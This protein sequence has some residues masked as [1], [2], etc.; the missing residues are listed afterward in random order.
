ML[1]RYRFKAPEYTGNA[2]ADHDNLTRAV[3]EYFLS[4]EQKNALQI[5]AASGIDTTPVGAHA[6]ST[7]AFTTLSASKAASIAGGT[8]VIFGKPS[9]SLAANADLDINL[10]ASG[11]LIF[12]RQDT[13]GGVVL[14]TMENGLS[15]VTIVSDPSAR[16]AAGDPGAGTNKI[17]I[18]AIAGPGL[19]LRNRYGVA[20]AVSIGIL[21]LGGTPS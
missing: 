20:K 21:S 16:A 4:L 15:T 13:D 17:G 3:T 18:M 11:V 2:K 14:A 8:A 10:T 7:G 5:D 9:T 6:P 1:T 19:R 12:M